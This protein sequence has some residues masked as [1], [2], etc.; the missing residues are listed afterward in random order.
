VE[1][2]RERKVGI[3][4]RRP[5]TRTNRE[6]RENGIGSAVMDEEE[7]A[8]VRWPTAKTR[9]PVGDYGRGIEGRDDVIQVAQDHLLGRVSQIA[10]VKTARKTT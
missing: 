4:R 6:S 8:I 9:R 3:D 2:G 10:R 7:R 1:A 5:S